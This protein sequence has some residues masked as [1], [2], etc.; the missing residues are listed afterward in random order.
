V[1]GAEGGEGD[2]HVP[3]PQSVAASG[4]NSAQPSKQRAVK[5]ALSVRPS[6]KSICIRHS[7]HKARLIFSEPP[8]L[9]NHFV[10]CI[11]GCPNPATKRHFRNCNGKPAIGD[12][13]DSARNPFLDQLLDD[14]A[15]PLLVGAIDDWRRPVLSANYLTQP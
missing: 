1:R 10:A 13:M 12:V 3:N 14:P 6:L 4:A 8:A 7:D 5:G 9:G 15:A 11:D 2:G